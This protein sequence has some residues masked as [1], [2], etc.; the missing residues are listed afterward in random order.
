MTP[1]SELQ[2]QFVVERIQFTQIP[3]TTR[4]YL[5]YIS[6]ASQVHRFYAGDWRDPIARRALATQIQAQN[7]PRSLLV[8]VLLRQNRSLGGDAKTIRNI[9]RLGNASTLAVVTGQQA[10]LFG[11]PLYTLTKALGAAKWAERLSA[12]GLVAVPIF[13]AEIEDHDISEVDHCGL[14]DRSGQWKEIRYKPEGLKEGQPIGQGVLDHRIEQTI[15][16]LF[17]ALPNSDFVQEIRSDLLALHIPGRSWADA[18]G[19]LML[20]LTAG[21]GL[22]WM[23]PSDPALKPSLAPLYGQT[24][25]AA[26][27]LAS[28][29]VSRSDELLELGYHDQIQFTAETVPLFILEDHRRRTMGQ[30][31]GKFFTRERDH[32]WTTEE[33]RTEA[34]STPE[35]F[36]QS[37]ALRPVAQDSLLPTL[38]YVGGPAEIAYFA[39]LQPLYQRLERLQPLLAPRPSITVVE[40]RHAKTLERYRL[41]LPDL[42]RPPE[43]LIRQVAEREMG[44]RLLETFPITESMVR[45]QMADVRK[46]LIETD[47]TL[48]DA[49]DTALEKMLYQVSNLR[50]KFVSAQARRDE[51]REQQIRRA[52]IA[53]APERRLQ[54]R[55]VN[56]LYFYARYGSDFPR[57]LYHAIDLDQTDQLALSLRA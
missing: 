48:G 41:G 40:R 29:L 51:T 4:L 19:G 25:Q 21:T 30:R 31:N 14:P 24:I 15:E 9:E 18:F 57:W 28:A 54:E 56:G 1:S 5:D 26:S 38:I 10:G 6:G 49:V 32:E 33:L 43:D 47:P 45:N 22:V 11:G 7:L 12:E 37:A 8:E 17:A 52:C 3:R 34:L 13:W 20:K 36:S 42:F 39:Q 46:Q 27:N 35:K 44:G 50:A 2:T 16:E 53:L 23:N 55:L